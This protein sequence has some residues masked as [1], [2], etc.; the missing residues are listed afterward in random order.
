MKSILLRSMVLAALALSIA[1]CGGGG[2]DD[3]YVVK[4]RFLQ[5]DGQTPGGVLYSG[6]TLKNGG[7][8]LE[9]KRP[10]PTEPYP[11]TFAFPTR[12]SY[13]DIYHVTITKQP[14]QQECA[15]LSPNLEG[16]GRDVAGR[17]TDIDVVIQCKVLS[18]NVIVTVVNPIKDVVLTN[19]STGGSFKLDTTTTEV[20]FPVQY[21]QSYGIAVVP[22]AGKP[23]LCTVENASGTMDREDIKNV[24]VVCSSVVAQ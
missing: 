21:G 4:G 16:V 15:V 2:D 17:L 10:A 19:G 3:E 12:L 24:K 18:H 13:G 9:I 23:P 8:T 22:V 20:K 14:D 5:A 11:T 6:L 7:D 1:G